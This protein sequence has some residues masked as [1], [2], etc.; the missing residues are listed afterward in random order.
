MEGKMK[1]PGEIER[2]IVEDKMF[3]VLIQL[4]KAIRLLT[5]EGYNDKT[6]D[7][8]RKI[9]KHLRKEMNVQRVKTAFDEKVIKNESHT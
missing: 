1:S 5:D 7:P 3:T 4:T 9:V 6:L 2:I 8:M